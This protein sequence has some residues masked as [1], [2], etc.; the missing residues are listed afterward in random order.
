[1]EALCLCTRLKWFLLKFHRPAH[2][3]DILPEHC[4]SGKFT[5]SL[6]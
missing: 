5:G 6:E 4:I 1:M 2:V 3:D